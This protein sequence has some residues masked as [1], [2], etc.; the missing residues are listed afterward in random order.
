MHKISPAAPAGQEPAELAYRRRN[1]RFLY[2]PVAS[3]TDMG[4]QGPRLSG[5]TH[6]ARASRA[7]VCHHGRHTTTIQSSGTLWGLW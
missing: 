2:A 3:V 5:I 6:A 7:F 4:A 1:G